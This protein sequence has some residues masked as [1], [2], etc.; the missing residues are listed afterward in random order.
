M[1]ASLTA[2]LVR[3][4][5]R[6][7]LRDPLGLLLTLGTAPFFVFFFALVY[8]NDDSVTFEQFVPSLLIFAVIMLIFSTAMAIARETEAGTLERL[9]LTPMR[10]GDYLLA[11][12]FVQGLL[13]IT[14][15]FLTF[16]VAL[17]LGFE[18]QGAISLALLVVATAALSTIGMGVFV[19]SLARSVSQA[20]LIASLLMFLLLL[21]SGAIFPVPDLRTLSIL[22]VSLT[23]LDL[24]PTVPAVRAL[25][26]VLLD[27]AAFGEIKADLGL[28]LFLSSL[29]FASGWWQWSSRQGN[30]LPRGLS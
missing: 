16:L 17:A 24:L 11:T 3:K 6:Q 26:T 15:L 23:A 18:S 19:A 10:A 12:S 22:G 27:D 2:A 9:R 5:G 14:S 28:I 30:H 25:S 7:H 20:F 21:F 13:G 4:A 1:R 8:R 29:F